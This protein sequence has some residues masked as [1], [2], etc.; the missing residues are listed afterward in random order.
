MVQVLFGN[1]NI[2]QVLHN[3]Q[4]VEPNEEVKLPTGQVAQ[5]DME[6]DL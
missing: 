6:E 5:V 3:V 4:A 2:E 1:A